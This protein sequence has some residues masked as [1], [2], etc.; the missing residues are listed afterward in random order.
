MQT[1]AIACLAVAAMNSAFL[2]WTLWRM[3]STGRRPVWVGRI[4]G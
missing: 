2:L 4:L 3:S 1:I